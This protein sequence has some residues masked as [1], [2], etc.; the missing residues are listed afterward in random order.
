M[1]HSP[2]ADRCADVSML[3]Q[4]FS[5]FSLFTHIVLVSVSVTV[6]V[7]LCEAA[8][9]AV[10]VALLCVLHTIH[11]T[12]TPLPNHCRISVLS[13][14]LVDVGQERKSGLLLQG[15]LGLVDCMGSS[16]H[17]LRRLSGESL[18][19]CVRV[20]EWIGSSLFLFNATVTWLW[21]TCAHAC[22]HA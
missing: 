11:F 22:M 1:T 8:A 13:Y 5:S 20:S 14:T 2:F 3:S 19:S 6:R 15:L 9:V 4:L 7:V 17:Q 16:M 10:A 21:C 18:V 12:V